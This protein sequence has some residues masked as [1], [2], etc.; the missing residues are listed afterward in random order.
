MKRG[1]FARGPSGGALVEDVLRPAVG[2][3]QHR[4]ALRGDADDPASASC[5]NGQDE[6]LSG[7]LEKWLWHKFRE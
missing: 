3:V 7:G 2:G 5:V 6:V 1:A 4:G